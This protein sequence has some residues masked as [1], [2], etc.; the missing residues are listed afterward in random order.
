MDKRRDHIDFE[1]VI[2]GFQRDVGRAGNRIL[3]KRVEGA[4]FSLHQQ[5]PAL[6]G[7]TMI[8]LRVPVAAAVM[9]ALALM[10]ARAEVYE[11]AGEPIR[12]V[13]INT[14]AY[15]AWIPERAEP[16]RGTLV[17]IPGRH[18]DGR[19]MADDAGWQEVGKATGFA[20]MGCQFT[21]G[22]PG[23]YQF[24]QRGEVAKAIN[25]AISKLAVLSKH[26]E[27]EKAPL[28]FWG[29]SAG[30]NVS[31][32][33]ADHFPERVAAFASSK[34]TGGP[35]G[36]LGRGKDEIPM[37]FA[38]GMQDKAEWVAGSKSN[39][40]AG[41]KKHAPW[42]VAYQKNEGHDIGSSLDVARPFLKAAI[43]LRLSPAATTGGAPSIFKTPPKTIG[44]TKTPAA[45]VRLTKID[46]R[47]GWLGDPEKME[48]APAATFKG[49]KAKAIWLPGRDDGEGLAGVSAEI[50]TVP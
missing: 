4:N 35:G 7:E 29:T 12:D 47:T 48:I 37:F 24:D 38:V 42:T 8:T 36:Q 18:G 27:L 25:T 41:L 23:L 44:G 46:P 26:P 32:K 10:D 11:W 20:V 49:P 17:L 13:Q 28:A 15:K 2:D 43:E 40:E 5:R 34:G 21:D 31:A 39:I 30:S 50:M 14:V 1:L 19:G 16:L 22:E 3:T 6:S 9:L 33:Y 45:P